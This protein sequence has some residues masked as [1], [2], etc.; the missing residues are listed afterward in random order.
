MKKVILLLIDALMPEVL[1]NG[2]ATNRTPA[3]KFLVNNGVLIR[4]C[5]TAFPT[6]TAT[7]DATLMMGVYADQHKIPGLIWYNHDEKRLIDYING[8]RTVFNLGINL[9]LQDVMINL[10]EKHLNK[11][12]KTIFEEV[13]DA[14]RT[15]ASL[16]FI[17]HRGRNRH[18]L[19]LPL[20]LNIFTMFSMNKKEVSGPD[21]LSIGA[22]CK[23]KLSKRKIFWGLNQSFLNKYGINDSFASQV[24]KA[25]IVSGHQPDLMFIYFPD[26]DHYLHKHIDQPLLN[27]EKVDR[28]IGDILDVFG[29]WERAIAQ[30]TFIIIGDHGQTAIGNEKKYNIDLDQM[31]QELK[32][33]KVGKKVKE[34][35]EVI[36]A[37]N[38]RMAYI[39]P[40]KQEVH[41][42]IRAILLKDSR[43]DF[44]AW[45]MN[46]MV[47]VEKYDG[48]R[49][50]FS[51][52]GEYVDPYD[53]TWDIDGDLEILDI[54]MDNNKIYFDQYP[55]ALSRLYGAL[56][57][58]DIPV[59][60]V[61]A[62]TS[63]EFK[64]KTFPNHLGGGSHGS[65]H[66]TDSIVPLVVTGAS[67]R[68]KE[69]IRI[70]DLK[71]YILQLLHINQEH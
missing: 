35:D 34:D 62:R 14:G 67:K 28:K 55:D 70:V 66:K 58:Q 32:I 59:F 48:R 33:V 42:N 22:M 17:I 41:K 64:S 38:E 54:K 21:M 24:A 4:D 13:A 7:V 10:N 3:L 50:S 37:N 71:D 16:N 5:V 27:L 68:P 30:T 40:L 53:K 26:H 47:I 31:L 56:F 39:Y 6:M 57:S 46:G 63:Y 60:V 23:P 45:K 69:G 19:R 20:L 29:S 52:N 51:K 15:S 25:I 2:I 49:L 12:I 43:I 18:S 11:R 36:I 8:A 61:S 65:L 1:E 9:T 44:V